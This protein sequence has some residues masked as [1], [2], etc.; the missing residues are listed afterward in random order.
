MAPLVKLRWNQ[1]RSLVQIVSLSCAVYL[2]KC[3]Q[4]GLVLK[5]TLKARKYL[6]QC[7]ENIRSFGWL[8]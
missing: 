8:V 3:C 4:T 6:G 7:A 5:T 1:S 2:Q